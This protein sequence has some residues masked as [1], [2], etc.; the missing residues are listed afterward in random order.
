MKTIVL[1]SGYREA[2]KDTFVNYLCKKHDFTKYAFAGKLKDETNDSYDLDNREGM[3]DAEQ[4]MAPRIHEP[5]L[6]KDKYSTE[7]QKMI[8]CNFSTAKGSVPTKD[9]INLLSRDQSGNYLYNGDQLYWTLRAY[10]VLEGCTKRTA[11]PNHWIH[12]VFKQFENN[13]KVA[14]CDWRYPNESDEVDVTFRNTHKVIKV[15][16]DTPLG[17]NSADESERVL[18]NYLDFDVRIMNDKTRGLEYFY[19]LIESQFVP[20]YE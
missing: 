11:R 1:V 15:R 13:E 9:T 7:V 19:S 16:I 4:K 3:E 14:V 6:S 12:K 8:F 18:D 20:F 17:S 5:V 10:L 2:G